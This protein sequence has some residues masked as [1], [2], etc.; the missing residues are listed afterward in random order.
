MK[1]V[2]PGRLEVAG[3]LSV[4]GVTRD[5][6]VPVAL[7]QAG[8]VTTASGTFTIRRLD[9]KIG[10]GEWTDTSMVADDVQVKFRLAFGGVGPL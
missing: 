3:R 2:A 6:T 9:F 5:V 1:L 4:K 10:E 8:G 7:A